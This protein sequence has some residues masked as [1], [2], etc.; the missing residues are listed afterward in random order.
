[1]HS[2][3]RL[4]LQATILLPDGEIAVQDLPAA[5]VDRLCCLQELVGGH[6]EVVPIDGQRYLVFCEVA[7]DRP[8]VINKT[9]TAIAHA[10]ESIMVDDYLAGTVVLLPQ[11]ALN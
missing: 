4:G 5:E 11:H 6:L 3:E 2:P 7:K 10:S 8:H 1:M 9:A